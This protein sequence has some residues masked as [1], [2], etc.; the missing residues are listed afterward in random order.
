VWNIAFFVSIKTSD[1]KFDEFMFHE[2]TTKNLKYYDF[3]AQESEVRF[4]RS[5]RNCEKFIKS[6]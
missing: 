6:F 3:F 4:S 1:S 2:P 5:N